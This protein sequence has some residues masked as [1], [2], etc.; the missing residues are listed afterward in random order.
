M[1]GRC[2]GM[3]LAAHGLP[4]SLRH[5]FIY[6]VCLLHPGAMPR[7]KDD[8]DLT[9][10]WDVYQE[11]GYSAIRVA[12]EIYKSYRCAKESTATAHISRGEC[13]S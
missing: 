12:R 1:A 5:F 7:K 8:T 4:H 11:L 3:V 9:C 2:R 13:G 6:S 10:K